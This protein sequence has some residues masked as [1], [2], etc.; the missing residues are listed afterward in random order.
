[1]AVSIV[2]AMLLLLLYAFIFSFSEQDGETSGGLSYL[3]SRKCVEILN[4]LSGKNWTEVF[5][6]SLTDYFHNPIRKLAHFAEYAVMGSL[7]YILWRPWRERNYKLYLLIGIW[8]FV[9]AAGDEFHQL[10]VPGRYGNIADVFLD[11]CGGLFGMLCCVRCEK[12]YKKI[13]KNKSP[14]SESEP[15]PKS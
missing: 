10:F 3:I 2:A 13:S 1:M 12:T 5:V 8:V 14:V 15:H 7:L 4:A 11:T 9:S 6:E